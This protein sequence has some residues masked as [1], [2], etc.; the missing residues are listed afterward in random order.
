[1]KIVIPDEY[2][3]RVRSLQCF[4]RLAGHEVVCVREPARDDD[5]LIELLRDAEAI[6]AIRERTTLSAAVIERLPRLK[7][8]SLV[9][10]R[11]RAIDVDACTARSVVVTHGT[12]ASPIAPAELTWAL[13]LASR[14]HVV[15]EV[16]RMRAGQWPHT[17]SHRLRGSTLGIYGLGLIGGL[18]AEAGRGFGM[19]VLVLGR[20][21]S[22]AAARAQG[23][24]V[25]RD[26]AELFEQSDV[27]SLNLR[28][29]KETRGIVTAQDLA[30]MKPS[31][32]IV[33]TA[34]AELIAPGA[35]V[36][37]LRKGRP[38]F[39]AVDVYEQEPVVNGEHPLLKLPNAVCSPHLG[40]AEF[41]TWELYFGEAFDNIVAYAAGKPVNVANPEVLARR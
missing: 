30:R 20:E 5:H 4:A 7:L 28:L 14:R 18:V 15:D 33:N 36:E 6:V 41:D 8:V 3:D 24:D 11:S 25:A 35:L 38:G 9:G 13:I 17:L 21:N 10:R 37:A 39:A 2:Q 16:T 12:Q 31:A 22:A 23:Y 19:R 27:L 26:Q 40:W 1:M 29:S 34:R 32:L